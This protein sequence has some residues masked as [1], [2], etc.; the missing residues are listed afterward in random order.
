MKT[1]A[2]L[3][4]LAAVG[5]C[6]ML[7]TSSDV[8]AQEAADNQ[9]SLEQ[10][11]AALQSELERIRGMLPAQAVAMT[12]VEYNF[13]NLWFAAH[14]ENWSLAQFF[15]SETRARLRWA[16]RIVPRRRIS[17]GEVVLQPFLD[18]FEQ[19]HYASI[20]RSLQEQDV[21]AFE[22]AYTDALDAC[23][24]CH[25]ASEKEFLQLRKPSVPAGALID[26]DNDL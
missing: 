17:S 8:G 26:F 5:I 19:P 16:L 25:V 23:Y 10:E 24:S 21:A 14:E 1:S 18:A 20:E 12:V 2:L 3:L 11:V 6:T 7:F 9:L 13:S 22:A 15:L 4:S